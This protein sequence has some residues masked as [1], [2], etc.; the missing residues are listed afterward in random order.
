MGRW[1]Q[2]SLGLARGLAFA[3]VA[4][5]CLGAA[6]VGLVRTS[7]GLERLRPVIVSQANHYLSATLEIDR[8]S[9]SLFS[10]IALDGVRLSRDGRAL[11]RIERVELDYRIGELT[12]AG[13]VIR[14]LR[15]VHPVVDAGRQADG[16]WDLAD[17]IRR[18]PNRPAGGP[19]RPL[20]IDDLEVTDGEVMLR[21][22]LTVGAAR[23]PTRFA[24]L[25]LRMRVA[26]GPER[27]TLDFEHGAFEGHAPE[28]TLNGLTGRFGNTET[29][30]LFEALHV[31]TP[32]S[33]FTLDGR[34]DR[35]A[36]PSTIDL[37]VSGPR[38]A[39]QEWSGV[40]GGLRNIAVE[41]AVEA[42]IAGP[43]SALATTLDLHST[44]GDVRG[45]V[46]LDST[47]PGWHARGRASVARL[48][49]ARW[50][51]RPERPSDITGEVD[52]D[53][54]LQLGGHFPVGRFSFSGTHAGYMEYEAD[55]VRADG[56]LTPTEAQI[57]RATATAYG[58]NVRLGASAMAID[59]P[60]G[61]RFAGTATGV[62]LRQV[63]RSV[64]VPHVESS[65][66][67][68]FDVTGRFA[69]PVL[70]GSARFADS[71]FLGARLASGAVGSIDT[72]VEPFHYTGAGDLTDVDLNHFG[73]EL[74]IAWLTEPR[75]AGTLAGRFHVDG[76]GSD[77]ATMTLEGGGRLASARLFS[78]TLSDAEV[79][80]SIAS[81]SLHATYDGELDNVDPAIPMVDPLYAA[82]LS[83]HT[84]A[85]VAVR[86][87]LVRSPE[88][89]DYTVA[90]T[91]DA[92]NSR[93][94][95]IDIA[96]GHVEATIADGA[97]R[98]AR[99]TLSG[100]A[101]D[102]DAS[103]TLELDGVRASDVAYS[104]KRADLDRLRDVLGYDLRGRAVSSGRMTGPS[105]T[106]RF[107]GAGTV[108]QLGMSGVE[109]R[110]TSLEYDVTL[111]T[112]APARAVGT[113][114]ARLNDALV[115]GRPVRTAHAR[116]AY[117]AGAVR[118]DLDS[119][120]R[121][122]LDA[123][124][125][126]TLDLDVSNRTA[127]I[128]SLALTLPR[129]SWRLGTGP[130][131]ASWTDTGLR[132][133]D[134][135]L[136]DEAGQQQ[137]TLGGTWD[138]AGGGAMRV[139]A[140]GLRLES[141]LMDDE[142]LARYGGTLEGSAVVGGSFDHP[143]VSAD[144]RVT[145]G[146]IRRLAYASFGGHVDFRDD[147]LAVDVRLDQAPGVWLTAVGTVPLSAFDRTRT[148][149]PMQLAVK[150]S[151]VS[152]TLLEGVT[153]VVRN[154]TGRMRLD[155]TVLGNAA[156]PL[157]S[158]RVEVADAAFDVVSSGARY[159][160]GRMALNLATERVAV[161]MLHVEDENGHALEVTGS[162][163]TRQLRVSDL[164]V[165]VDARD[166]QVLR[167]QYGRVDIDARLNLTGQFESPRLTGR[168]TVTG[169][170][171]N[172]D[173][174]LDRTLFQPYATQA[175]VP[176]EI[177]PI[178]ALN[179]WERM[180]MDLELHVPGT[181][182]ME[183]DNVQVSPGT[184]L[185]LGNINLR[186]FGDLYLYKDP[187]QPMYVNGSFDSLSGT[188]VFQ[189]RRFDLDPG[190]S[191]VF[192]SDLNPEL[193][194]TVNRIIS[195]V[196]TR[197]SIVGPLQQPELRLA[198]TPPLEPSDILSLIVF[199]TSTNELSALQQQQLAV[200]A[201]TLAAGFI[202]APM[203]AALERTLGIDTLEIEPGTDIRGG[204]RVTVGNEIAPGL[205]ARFSRQFG[206]ADYDEATL[207]Y[208]L[209]RIL[210]IRA[211]FSDAGTL[212]ARS[213]FRRVERAG[214]DLLL[215]FS[216]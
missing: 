75:Y 67:F 37:S 185:G 132:L 201:G 153:D 164:A 52:L 175:A 90:A 57:A 142:A 34:T 149:Q 197:V 135:T 105:G 113:M 35:R 139:G 194:V 23:V 112:D 120:I 202:A 193:Y 70:T 215:F 83:G 157:F 152:L 50:L 68:D 97:L 18:D 196:E 176:A 48:D 166:F 58:A 172:V 69:N 167:N 79:S 11:V 16:R 159:Q 169:G 61:F 21:S 39:F 80:V 204:P 134:A 179:P 46:V 188:Y 95:G 9:G 66:A 150:S 173:R 38:V 156:A 43:S 12:G 127:S 64:P 148:P 178:V 137:L 124:L 119:T 8:L 33:E 110:A 73:R 129:T 4:L 212:T 126:T 47:V 125:L 109:A 200:R 25:D 26:T 10:G 161:D 130:V 208:Y 32:R 49:L 155:V 51:N 216:F 168:L 22:P 53:V 163:G 96:T 210:R 209:S 56:V 6:I 190:S 54:D 104:V 151:D 44:G 136:L 107:V 181:L 55:D 189:G 108:T 71:E 40:L 3:V 177:D 146:R 198:S 145:G 29:G 59:A 170:V 7:W 24:G 85:T 101:V 140:R 42:T 20:R 1:R 91:L 76:A 123:H 28:L 122:G 89:D 206:A 192:R 82:R 88:L 213:P 187:A 94:R 184:P 117:D 182:R 195:G 160:R 86:D 45:K 133:S 13:S 174:I 154:V 147:A 144:L 158:G 131:A 162:L 118:A 87:L 81:G 41:S 211:T 115:S 165:A 203:V 78:G 72:V 114:D 102:M 138:S 14:R 207:E 65:L 116:L 100:P 214:I 99:L 103:G 60:Y 171:L 19:R 17:L 36:T 183:G 62:D 98:L 2:V 30:W 27:W 63:P 15:L 31:R 106:L 199:N 5:L 121:E 111:P 186:A 77:L 141:L 191:I 143:T 92:R 74:Q 84:Q 128:R 93:V 180:G 205:V